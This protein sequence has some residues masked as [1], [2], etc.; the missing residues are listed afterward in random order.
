MKRTGSY[1]PVESSVVAIT[2]GLLALTP[3]PGHAQSDVQ[4]RPE[5]GGPSTS[6]AF[7]QQAVRSGQEL[8]LVRPATSVPNVVTVSYADFVGGAAT[9]RTRWT[10]DARGE[11]SSNA[12]RN[13][14]AGGEAGW[15]DRNDGRPNDDVPRP[16]GNDVPAAQ[17][18]PEPISSALVG[19]GLVGLAWAR[20]RKRRGRESE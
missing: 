3:A 17:V 6:E 7:Y 19:S 5:L 9:D 18:T 15:V 14:R 11:A 16:G 20:W 2:L 8:S 12:L 13:Y 1:L 4:I 10:A